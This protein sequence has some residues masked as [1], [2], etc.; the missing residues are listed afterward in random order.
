[1]IAGAFDADYA[2]L[3]VDASTNAFES[4]FLQ[5]GQTKE[6]TVL[7]RSLGVS[8]LLIAVNKIDNCQW[9]QDRFEYIKQQMLQFLPSVGFTELQSIFV[10]CSGLGGD[11]IVSKSERAELS[12]YDGRSLLQELGKINH[13]LAKLIVLC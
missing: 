13:K 2:V 1:M 4:G 9:S 8:K 10:P 6:H 11:N 7:V 5:G 12:W 3:V